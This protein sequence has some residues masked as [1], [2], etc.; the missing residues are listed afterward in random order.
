MAGSHGPT[1][2]LPS[3]VNYARSAFRVH[4]GLFITSCQVGGVTDSGMNNNTHL[5]GQVLHIKKG[6]EDEVLIIYNI[7][8]SLANILIKNIPKT[9]L[10]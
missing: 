5:L 9:A 7:E 2:K 3:L 8:I 6:E 4:Y 10:L 1:T